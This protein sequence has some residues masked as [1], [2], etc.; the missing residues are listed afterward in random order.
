MFE[1]ACWERQRVDRHAKAE[2]LL[3][4]VTLKT[5][6]L[7]PPAGSRIPEGADPRTEEHQG[8]WSESLGWPCRPKTGSACRS[9]S[10]HMAMLSTGRASYRDTDGAR[11][12]VTAPMRSSAASLATEQPPC[13]L[14]GD[15]EEGA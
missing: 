5:W 8:C 9:S 4:S 1:L 6:C 10:L 7:W 11:S 13:S 12:A 15:S 2:T 14:V 3:I